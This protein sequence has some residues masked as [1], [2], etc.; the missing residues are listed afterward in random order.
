MSH[1]SSDLAERRFSPSARLMTGLK[2]GAG[3]GGG[4]FLAGL[5]ISPE[6]VW[7]GFLMGFVFLT[8]LALAGPVFLAFLTMAGARWSVALQRVPECMAAALPAAAAMGVVLLGH[9]SPVTASMLLCIGDGTESDCCGKPNVSQASRLD[10][11]MQ[12]LDGPDCNC[13]ITVAV[14][15]ATTG[16]SSHKLSL[17]IVSGSV[18]PRNIA[19]LAEMRILRAPSGDAYDTRLSSLRTVILLI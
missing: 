7:G 12:H 11:S 18:L 4:V 13:C 9:L 8:A 10:E 17:A 3:L 14:A 19:T 2:W 1:A 6:R 15:P 16:T 5:F